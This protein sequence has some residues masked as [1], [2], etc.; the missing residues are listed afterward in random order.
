MHYCSYCFPQV[1]LDMEEAMEG[2][3][4][5]EDLIKYAAGLS[6]LLLENCKTIQE[7]QSLLAP[8]DIGDDNKVRFEVLHA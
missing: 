3:K 7:A 2:G 8:I 4:L 6:T 1:L 5:S